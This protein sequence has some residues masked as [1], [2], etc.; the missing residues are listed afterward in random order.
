[1]GSGGPQPSF[2]WRSGYGKTKSNRLV[3]RSPKIRNLQM[4]HCMQKFSKYEKTTKTYGLGS[5]R[6]SFSIQGVKNSTH[7]FRSVSE[8]SFYG[9]RQ[10]LFEDVYDKIYDKINKLS[11]FKCNPIPLF[12]KS[13]DTAPK[14]GSKYTVSMT[15]NSLLNNNR[16]IN[17]QFN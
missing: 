14:L 6:P 16:S 17:I 9:H 8:A 3:E 2:S 4:C 5:N 11:F 7:S 13:R 12:N 1:M 10:V 15:W